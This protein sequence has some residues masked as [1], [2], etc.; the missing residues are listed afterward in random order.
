LQP[1][2]PTWEAVGKRITQDWPWERPKNN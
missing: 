2:L 1:Q